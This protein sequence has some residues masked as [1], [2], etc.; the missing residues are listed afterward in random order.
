MDCEFTLRGGEVLSFKYLYFSNSFINLLIIHLNSHVT[1]TPDFFILER[2]F[3]SPAL[4]PRG[5]SLPRVI[6]HLINSLVAITN[7]LS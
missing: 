5:D 7:W 6:P 4:F 2:V 1:H 3:K